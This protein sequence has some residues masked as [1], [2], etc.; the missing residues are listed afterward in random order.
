MTL[1]MSAMWSVERDETAHEVRALPRA[2][3]IWARRLCDRPTR[4]VRRPGDSTTHPRKSQARA[5]I[6]CV[7]LGPARLSPC[8]PREPRGHLR[9]SC[10]EPH[11]AVFLPSLSPPAATVA[12][13]VEH[14][15]RHEGV[16]TFRTVNNLG[17][18]QVHRR[19]DS[20]MRARRR[21]TALGLDDK[22]EHL[23]GG[24]LGGFG[25]RSSCRPHRHV[26]CVRRLRPRPSDVHPLCATL[27]PESPPLRDVSTAEAASRLPP[28]PCTACPSP[29]DI[30]APGT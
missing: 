6:S 24:N 17:H 22:I 3:S 16:D 26:D 15:F 23:A 10:R 18:A 29:I 1:T 2:R 11:L 28:S 27:R 9:P 19:A 5:R 21:A 4:E 25:S 7:Q 13:F 20:N 30:N 14:C 8:R 12:L